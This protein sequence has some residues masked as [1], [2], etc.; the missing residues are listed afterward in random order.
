MPTLPAGAIYLPCSQLAAA[1]GLHPYH[2]PADVLNRLWI[3]QRPQ[4][5]NMACQRVS[6][7]LGLTASAAKRQKE[8]LKAYAS[9]IQEAAQEEHGHKRADRIILIQGLVD[10]KY[11]AALVRDVVKAARAVAIMD[12]RKAASIRSLEGAI[13]ATQAHAAISQSQ[14]QQQQALLQHTKMLIESRAHLAASITSLINTERGKRDESAAIAMQTQQ[15]GM[16][17][18]ESNIHIYYITL[19]SPDWQLGVCLAGKVDGWLADSNAICEVKNRQHR[20]FNAVPIYERVQVEAYLRVTQADSCQFFEKYQNSSWS[21]KLTKDEE[22]W[23]KVL[24]GLEQFVAAFH[25]LEHD[26]QLQEEVV[27]RTHSGCLAASN[28]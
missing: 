3:K 21:T 27:K 22:L 18:V 24:Q 14:Y 25:D 4:Q 5:Y 11:H 2:V 7:V 23:Q 17:V 6:A 16:A 26:L 10:F 28:N 20:L 12:K 8:A 9:T 19:S 13:K 15:Q 1:C